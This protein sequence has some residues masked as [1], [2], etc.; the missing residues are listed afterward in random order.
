MYKITLYDENCS[1]I[2]DGT[3]SFFV[4]EIDDFERKWFL[5]AN[6][7]QV[8]RYKRSKAGEIVTDYYSDS[9]ELNIFQEDTAARVL[10]HRICQM[11]ETIFELL[12]TYGYPFMI[13]AENAE[14]RVRGIEFNKKYYVV[15]QYKLCG[16]CKCM[17]FTDTLTEY[18][19][20]HVWGNPI[21]ESNVKH[22]SFWKDTPEGRQPHLYTK[23]DYKDDTIETYCWVTIAENISEEELRGYDVQENDA[24]F[25]SVLMRD[26]P[27]EAG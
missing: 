7:S 23:E 15:G 27:G 9:P 2:C 5:Q 6:E 19:S 10:F 20:V 13:Y 14:I 11:S 4:D 3:T 24:E 22:K 26:I 21:C 25:F 18:F 16:V 8:E 1:P 12:N 17:T